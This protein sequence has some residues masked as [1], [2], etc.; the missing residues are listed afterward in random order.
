MH[1]CV[2]FCFPEMGI[3]GMVSHVT[4]IVCVTLKQNRDRQ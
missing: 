2:T 1:G 3:Y 4:E